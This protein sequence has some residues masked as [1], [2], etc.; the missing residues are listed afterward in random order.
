MKALSSFARLSDRMIF[1]SIVLPIIHR[2]IHRK[3]GVLGPLSDRVI[4]TL[5]PPGKSHPALPDR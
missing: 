2:L 5:F 1:F 3:R 4:H